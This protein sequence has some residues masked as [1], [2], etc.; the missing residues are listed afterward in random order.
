MNVL[1]R[2]GADAAER[3]AR[4]LDRARALRPLLAAAAPRIEAGRELP[5]DVL[6]AMHANR[7]F[8]LLLPRS[9]DGEELEPADYVQ[10]VEAIAM[11]DASVA[12][13]M[14]QGTGCSMSAAYLAPDVAAKVFGPPDAVLAWGQLRGSR[15]V[16]VD[17]GYRVSGAW[18]FVSGGRHASWIGG[19]CHVVERDGSLRRDPDGSLVERTMLIPRAA[20]RRIDDWSV[21]GLRG[22]GSDTFAVENYF[23]PD[24]HSLRRDTDPERRERGTLY[25]FS[26]NNIY[27]A[28]FASV[29][30]GLARAMLDDFIALAR[31]KTPANYGL[32][33]RENPR[34]CFETAHA[35]TRLRA[36][37][38]HLLET[39]REAWEAVRATHPMPLEMR[40]RIR[41][42]ATYAIH[43]A[44]SVGDTV[45][46]EAGATAIFEANPFERRYRDLHTVTQQA[47]GRAQHFETV[48]TWMLGGTPNARFL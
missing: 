46:N 45:W 14:N 18:A 7:L 11:G 20:C 27:A 43:T 24:E 29:G 44:R 32:P 2:P 15:A 19:H 9:V 16:V 33:L 39:L 48:G 42:A 13:C 4:A 36:A 25:R 28:G 26:T 23:V 5:P 41:A 12:W 1:T 34:V 30:L 3:A 6:A 8:R 17:G 38:A 31:E 22:T 10:C 40:T 47:Q 37:R 21:F 35:D